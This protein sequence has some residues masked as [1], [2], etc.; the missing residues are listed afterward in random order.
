MAGRSHTRRRTSVPFQGWGSLLGVVLLLALYRHL[1]Q[2][3]FW[4]FVTLAVYVGLLRVTLCRVETLKHRP[5][6]WRVRGFL[7]TCE[8]HIGLKRG[9]PTLLPS[10]RLALPQFMWPR[11]DLAAAGAPY[12]P[13]PAPA[14]GWSGTVSRRDRRL[15]DARLQNWIG[16]AALLVGVGQLVVALVQG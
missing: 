3:S 8:F 1:W 6:R 10:G 5:C 4:I 15:T 13:Q 14:A 9:L 7:R 2:A 11:T 12:E 16:G